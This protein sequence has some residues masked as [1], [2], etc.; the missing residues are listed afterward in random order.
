MLLG[1]WECF[2]SGAVLSHLRNTLLSNE[3][4]NSM[5]DGLATTCNYQ[6]IFGSGLY[7]VYICLL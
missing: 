5:G 3:G 7:L 2:C 1:K 4:L 6:N